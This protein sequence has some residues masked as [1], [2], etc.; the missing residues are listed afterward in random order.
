MRECI[1]QTK[2]N[3]GLHLLYTAFRISEEEEN[4]VNGQSYTLVYLWAW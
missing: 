4:Y 3:E 2:M 1:V